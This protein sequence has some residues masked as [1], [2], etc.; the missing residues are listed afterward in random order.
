MPRACAPPAQI[1][2]RTTPAPPNTRSVTGDTD[3]GSISRV[4][5]HPPGGHQV[6]EPAQRDLLTARGKQPQ[7]RHVPAQSAIQRRLGPGPRA[8][9]KPG[10]DPGRQG[11]LG[12][13]QRAIPADLGEHRG[14]PADPRVQRV[15]ILARHR[16]PVLGGHHLRQPGAVV[17]PDL[18]Q[19]P[20]PGRFAQLPVSLTR[21]Q[22]RLRRTGGKTRSRAAHLG[23]NETHPTRPLNQIRMQSGGNWLLPPQAAAFLSFA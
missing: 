3:P 15:A 18:T 14:Q 12:T 11:L 19:N 1:A 23:Q 13:G 7:R 6:A 22:I 9:T 2:A 4:L 8:R 10:Y 20:G 5:F 16:R 17:P 21:H